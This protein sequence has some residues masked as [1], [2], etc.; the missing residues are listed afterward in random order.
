MLVRPHSPECGQWTGSAAGIREEPGP[1]VCTAAG[2]SSQHLCVCVCTRAY[3]Q[4]PGRNLLPQ[5]ALWSYDFNADR[6]LCLHV[7]LFQKR[8]FTSFATLA[9]YSK[10]E[11]RFVCL[12]LL[13]C[14]NN[15]QKA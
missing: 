9:G 12:L 11:Q 10:T 14:S 5:C 6:R 1:W 7:R 8:A 15:G 3:T 4:G 13:R 2:P